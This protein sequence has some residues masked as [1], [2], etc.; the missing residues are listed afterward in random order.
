MCQFEETI[1]KYII[2]LQAIVFDLHFVCANVAN[3]WS[4]PVS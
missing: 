4:K 3:C 2:A 1:L